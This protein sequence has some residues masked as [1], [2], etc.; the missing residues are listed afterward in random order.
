MT[1]HHSCIH[2]L[3]LQL[4]YIDNLGLVLISSRL[5]C[6]LY[7]TTF[8]NLSHWVPGTP[9]VD[10]QQSQI[11]LK[12]KSNCASFNPFTSKCGLNCLTEVHVYC[13]CRLCSLKILLWLPIA[14]KSRLA[15]E[16]ELSS[17]SQASRWS[18]PETDYA[19]AINVHICRSIVP[20]CVSV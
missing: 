6:Q 14:D 19:S 10:R 8:G 3:L 9:A 11:C 18:V 5:S 12:C 4:Q 2:N 20:G 13:D 7:L 1:G 16:V 15:C 17:T